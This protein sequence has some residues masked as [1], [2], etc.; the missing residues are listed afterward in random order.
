MMTIAVGILT[1]LA[2]A[3]IYLRREMASGRGGHTLKSGFYRVGLDVFA[4]TLL[5]RA[6]AAFTGEAAG[7]GA[8]VVSCGVLIFTAC[9]LAEAM[10]HADRPAVWPSG[11]RWF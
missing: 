2:A 7:I 8:L 6:F 9:L 10:R 4:F 5:V 3:L 1:A 11:W